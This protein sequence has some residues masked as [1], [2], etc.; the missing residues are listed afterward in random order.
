[1]KYTEIKDLTVDELVAIYRGEI[2][3]PN[4][5]RVIERLNRYMR[6]E[7]MGV[8]RKNY[9]RASRILRQDTEKTKVIPGEIRVSTETVSHDPYEKLDKAQQMMNE[10]LVEI[11]EL[12]AKKRSEREV[13]ELKE[14]YE[15]ELQRL[16]AIL[17]EAK[18]A[19][20][21]GML[22]KHFGN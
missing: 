20:V 7:P 6:G 8:V 2:S 9:A 22:R 12:E 21:V 11:A 15:K 16:Q 19:S 4:R 14:K 5:N 18:Q 10:A 17:V 1:M 3:F 13:A